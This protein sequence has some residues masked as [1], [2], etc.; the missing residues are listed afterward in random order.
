MENLTNKKIDSCIS[1][2]KV[3]SDISK[4]REELK[5]TKYSQPET[6]ENEI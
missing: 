3:L 1:M 4:E 2:A 5:I 6:I